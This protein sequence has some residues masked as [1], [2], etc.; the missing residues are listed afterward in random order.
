MKIIEK[1]AKKFVKTASSTARCEVKKTAIDMLPG[2]ATL[3]VAVV[4]VVIFRNSGGDEEETYSVSR[5]CVTNTTTTTNN[6]FFKELTEESI[7][8]IM[9]DR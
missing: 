7:K 3:A 4:A 6:Y 2:L 5:P 8:R 1:I 9:E